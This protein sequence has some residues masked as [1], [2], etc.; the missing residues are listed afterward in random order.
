METTEQKL[1]FFLGS[2]GNYCFLAGCSY[3]AI[4]VLCWHSMALREAGG[5]NFWLK[6]YIE[7]F[8]CWQPIPA[9]YKYPESAGHGV[10]QH[11]GKPRQEECLSPGV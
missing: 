10:M 4:P 6:K 2:V 8:K 5:R 3:V 9:I 1:M 7:I 11:F